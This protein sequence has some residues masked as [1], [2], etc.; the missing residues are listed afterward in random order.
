M[1]EFAS[2]FSS[3]Q[4]PEGIVAISTNTLRILS[5][6]KLG[7]VFNQQSWPL[8]LTPRK[9]II[10]PESGN[11]VV[12]ET[13][14][15]AYTSKTK[16]AKKQQLAEAMVENA[17]PDEEEKAAEIAANFLSEDLPEATFGSPKAGA[18][19]WASVIRI[20]DAISGMTYDKVELDQNEAA[21]S[22]ALVKFSQYGDIPYLLVGVAKDLHLNPRRSNG[23]TIHTYQIQE[24]GRR[25]ELMHV[26]P[27]EDVPQSIC[28]FQGRVLISIGRSLRV[29]EMGKRKLLRKCENKHFPHYIVDV[30]AFGSRIYVGDV[31]ESIY[32]VR[33]KRADNQ[34]VIFADDTIPRFV[35]TKC[36]LDYDTVAI[37][38]KFGNL[39]VV[40][41]PQDINDELDED[42]TGV[43]SLWD[44][45]WL[46]GSSQKVETLTSFH[47]GETI[48]SL[49]KATLIPGLS[50]CLVYTTISGAV[51]VMVPFTS[52]EDHEFFQHLEMHLRSE[53]SPLS[54][55][56]QL[57][58]RSYY[59]P[60]KN[61][62]DGDLCEQY[63]SIDYAK[64][65]AIA[66][67]LDRVPAE[68][69]KKLEDI[70][71]QYAF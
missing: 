38:D 62:I 63:N 50:E 26:T 19:Q 17:G 34:L 47:V 44:R 68:V 2:G 20:L 39:S 13:D 45:G 42:P 51:G 64:Q 43:K 21:V 67:D 33:Y 30:H 6:E 59:F 71:T 5:L 7:A 52:N 54:G 14:H 28:S 69:S 23:G 8:E 36:I 46:G 18:G 32:F 25:L 10:H 40:R 24:E 60:L 16:Q 61:V 11:I 57:S 35:T 56:D 53:N 1:L 48:L 12:I 4:C 37:A 31:Q 15:N 58:F 22:I 66:E 9:F 55:R 49:Q 27:V 65:K 70:R 41:L 29:Y 3:E